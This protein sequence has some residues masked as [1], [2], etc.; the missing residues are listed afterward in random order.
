MFRFF[1]NKSSHPSLQ[2]LDCLYGQ[3][4]SQLPVQEQM[5]YCTRLIERTHYQLQQPS[6]KKDFKCLKELLLAANAEMDRLE[7]IRPVR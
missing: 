3:T 1:R 2:Q 7:M 4:V 5:A 6:L